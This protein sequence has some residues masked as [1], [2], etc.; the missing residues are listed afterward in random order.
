[1]KTLISCTFHANSQ[2]KVGWSSRFY[3]KDYFV[4]YRFPQI[5]KQGVDHVN[6]IYVGMTNNEI[7]DPDVEKDTIIIRG[8]EHC[9]I[10]HHD[11]FAGMAVA[12]Q[13]A[14]S[15]GMDY[16]YLEHDCLVKGLGKVIEFGQDKKVCYGFGEYSYSPGWAEQSLVFVPYFFIPEFVRRLNQSRINLV[17]QI[18][19]E[20]AWHK[21]FDDMCTP[22]PFGYGRKQV[23][24]WNASVF[25]K[26][27]L[28][29]EELNKFM[30]M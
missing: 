7:P 30:E 26:Q 27:Q 20:I 9:G 10:K 1:M 8:Y 15:N 25:Y 21:T 14:Y 16:C 3:Q 23:R 24:D 29:D 28:T 12:A 5:A 2:R 17:T 13:Y 18:I 19:P 6:L 4:K 11:S 22:W